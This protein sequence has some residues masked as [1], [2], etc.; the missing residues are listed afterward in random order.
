MATALQ[1]A[2]RALNVLLGAMTVTAPSATQPGFQF[3]A[4]GSTYMAFAFAPSGS[5]EQ[6]QVRYGRTSKMLGLNRATFGYTTDPNT[7]GQ[8]GAPTYWTAANG[9]PPDL[10]FTDYIDVVSQALSNY[11]EAKDGSSSISSPGSVIARIW[12]TETTPLVAPASSAQPNDPSSIGSGPISLVKT[13][14]IPNWSQWSPNQ[15]INTIDITLLDMYG[16]VIPWNSTYATE[17]SAT[18]TLSE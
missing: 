3:V 7:G 9:G 1:V 6:Q 11:K 12:T 14:V 8:S 2:I 4:G 18:L 17:W 16:A 10:I 5:T 15:A 13:W